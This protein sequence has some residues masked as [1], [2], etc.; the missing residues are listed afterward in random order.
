MLFFIGLMAEISEIFQLMLPIVLVIFLLFFIWLLIK[1]IKLI[2]ELS[3]TI[4]NVNQT[5]VSVDKSLDKLQKPLDTAAHIA[6]TVDVAHNT[7]LNLAGKL[8]D[9]V[10]ENYV[11]IKE[12]VEDIFKKEPEENS[13]LDQ[14]EE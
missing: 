10:K 14:K 12:F 3:N 13:D 2:S 6:N 8:V 4:L 7:T 11:L 5:I 9:F 1:L